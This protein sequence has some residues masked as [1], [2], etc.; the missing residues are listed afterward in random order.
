MK[1]NPRL[2]LL[3]QETQDGWG[4]LSALDQTGCKAGLVELDIL[5]S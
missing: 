5:P 4:E 2:A 1:V 3:L